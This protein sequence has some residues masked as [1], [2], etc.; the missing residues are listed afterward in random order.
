MFLSDP[1]T[2]T[3]PRGT[4]TY[5]DAGSGTPLV[6][7]HGWPESSYCWE[8]VGRY[9]N[10][11]FHIIAPDLRGLGDSERTV[12]REH[13][14]KAELAQDVISMLDALGINRFQLV[15]HD[16]G[17]VVAQEVALAI[18]ERVSRLAIMNIAVINNLKG[19]MEVVEKVRSGSG[20]AYWYQHF[21]QAPGMA[22]AMIPGNEEVWIRYFLRGAEQ[23]VPEDSVAEYV[24]MYA[25]AGTPAAAANYYRT[26]DSD[27]KRWATLS[28]HVWPMPSIYIYGNRD[29]VIIPEYL[30]HIESCFTDIRVAEVKAGHFLQEEKPQEV[31]EHMNAF[32]EPASVGK[33]D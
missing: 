23:P 20:K 29:H 19:N 32:F 7:I 27:A 30:N 33:Q 3:T 9:L 24:R 6:M 28:D 12:G 2:L 22:E 18:P 16:W 21:Q 8:H 25:I 5:R 17:G 1:R 13:Y 10:A 11:G 14:H 26:F 4:F 31:A 15:G